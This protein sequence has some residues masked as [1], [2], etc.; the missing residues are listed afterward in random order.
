MSRLDELITELCP[1]G[2]EYKT[3]GTF[4]T[5][6]RGGNFQKKDFVENGEPIHYGQ[7]YTR[8]G[9]FAEETFTFIT[10]EMAA[11]QKFAEPGDIVMAIT[12]ENIE[13][14]CK[15]LCWMGKNRVAVSGHTAII[16][17]SIDPQYLAYYFHSTHFFEQKRK[18]AHGTKVIEVTPDK[19]VDIKIPVPPIEVQRE[20]VHILYN[21]T[22]LTAELTSELTARKKQYEYYKDLLLSF[23]DNGATIERHADRLTEIASL[24][25]KF[26]YAI[27]ETQEVKKDSFWIM[28]ATPKFQDDGIPYITSKKDRKSV[29]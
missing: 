17:H 11:R 4:A 5:V 21:F 24:Q 23:S 26:G 7:I 15:C 6:S 19:L 27:V 14:V 16:H 8:Y 13:D 2:V 22:K 25:K 29:V 3:L 9:L 1:N 18:L 20:I 28:P 10:K 12:S